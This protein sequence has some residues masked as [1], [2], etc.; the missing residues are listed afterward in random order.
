MV[1]IS[2]LVA[3]FDNGNIDATD[4]CIS[5]LMAS[6]VCRICTGIQFVVPDKLLT[7]DAGTWTPLL[8]S[9]DAHQ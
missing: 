9:H 8:F 6:D 7:S 4:C 2:L 3:F 1:N 5:R